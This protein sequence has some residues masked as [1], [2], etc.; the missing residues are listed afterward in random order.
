M[1]AAVLTMF[2]GLSSTYSLVNVAAEHIKMLL[3]NSVQTK[4]LV[5]ED[6]PDSQRHG[7]FADERLEWIKITNRLN[8][9]QIHWY[10]YSKPE[11]EVHKTFFEE[12]DAIA[13]DL[14]AA[15]SDADICFMHDIHYQG[16]HL[17]HNAAVRKVQEKLPGLRF[18]AVTHSAPVNRPPE[19]KYPFSLR[20]TPMPNT[21]YTYPTYSGIPALSK[22]YGIPEGRCRVI[23]NSMDIISFMSDE[24]KA[25]Q[26]KT[27]LLSPDILI[28]YPGRFTTGKK[29]EKVASLAGTIRRK[30]ELGVK[31]IFCDFPCMDTDAAKYKF[32]VRKIGCL[33]GLK[34]G[35]MVFTSD[36]GYPEGFPRTGVFDLFTLSNLF[37]C[38]S[39]SESFG[40]TVLEAASRGNFLVVNEAVPALEELGK[41]LKAYFMRWDARNFGFDTKEVYR[42]SEGAYME[43]HAQRIADMM[44]DNPVLFSKTQARQKFCPDWIWYNQLEPLLNEKA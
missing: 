18:I 44:R 40:L 29:F 11:G 7:I 5:S 32:A 20:Y 17:V 14:L 13:S 38:P 27:D 9:R 35:D 39:Y 16:W 4:M 23:Y 37:I 26:K 25:L 36:L 34:D 24:V 8:G 21:L 43:E 19:L 22:Q 1:I 6:C 12:A 2:N 15:L 42:P 33:S 10:D 41:K 31:V 28:V 3:D 30:T